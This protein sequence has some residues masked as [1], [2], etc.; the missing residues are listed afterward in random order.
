MDQNREKYYFENGETSNAAPQDPYYPRLIPPYP[1]N[2]FTPFNPSGNVRG[3]PPSGSK[4][5]LWNSGFGLFNFN[6]L[7]T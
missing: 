4:N 2:S 1:S 7:I 6:L 3:A 5:E